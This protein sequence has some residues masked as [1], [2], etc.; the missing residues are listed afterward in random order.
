MDKSTLHGVLWTV[1]IVLATL[2]ILSN[3]FTGIKSNF[4]VS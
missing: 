4:G 2:Y 1:A 3:Y